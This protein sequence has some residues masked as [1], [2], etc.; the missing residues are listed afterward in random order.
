MI[1]YINS[2]LPWTFKY[3]RSTCD[4]D[5]N[6]EIHRMS[7][8]RIRNQDVINYQYQKYLAHATEWGGGKNKAVRL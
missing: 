1:E 3:K 6:S 5:C 4:C 2:L 7:T 8:Q